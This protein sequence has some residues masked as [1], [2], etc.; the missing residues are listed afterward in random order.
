MAAMLLADMGA[1]V[2]RVDR[3]E[4]TAE[5]FSVEPRFDVVLRNR[6]SIALDV[7]K[8]SGLNLLLKL[9]DTSDALIEGFRP[10]VAERLG[11][12]PEVCMA[13]NPRLIYGRMTGFGQTG[14]L[15]QTAGHDLNYIALSGALSAIGRPGQR[16]VPPLNLV[17]D[18]GGGA[19]FLAFGIACALVERGRSGL[20]QVIDTAMIEGAALLMAPFFGWFASGAWSE[21]RGGNLLDGGAP[22][23]DTYE[24]ADGL[25]VAFGAIENKFFRSF[26]EATGLNP[27]FIAGQN[28]RL[29]W[30][31]LRQALTALFKSKSRAEWCAFLE[32][33]EACLT[34]VLNLAEAPNH[35][36]HRDRGSFIE[37][38]G[39]TQPSPAPRFSRSVSTKPAPPSVSGAETHAILRELGLEPTQIKELEAAGVIR[40]GS[41]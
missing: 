6:R 10:G 12:G 19:L 29:L 3:V 34:G 17:G 4:S 23:Y 9:I 7:R 36:H 2:I 32:G 11:F 41:T 14:P 31:E 15:A 20:G 35:A 21:P 26:A 18:Y 37:L 30:P 27:K 24:T 22:F 28:D 5:A 1:T 39:V 25:F 8:P 33:T 38:N 40:C 13:R 16:P